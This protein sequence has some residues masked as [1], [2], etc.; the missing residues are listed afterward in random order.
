MTPPRRTLSLWKKLLF[1]ILV[2]ALFFYGLDRAAKK[3]VERFAIPV[4]GRDVLP[5]TVIQNSRHAFVDPDPDRIWKLRSGEKHHRRDIFINSDGFRGDELPAD[6]AARDK[7]VMIGDSCVFG[8]GVG[9][10][11]TIAVLLARRLS[12]NGRSLTVINAGVPGYSSVQAL[13]HLERILKS[14]RPRI[15]TI[16]IGWN[17]SWPT[18]SL[19]DREIVAKGAR[20]ISFN[21]FIRKL[22][23]VRLAS[24][25]ISK[26][27]YEK[28]KDTEASGEARRRVSL[29]EYRENL[30]EMVRLCRELGATPILV[31][32]PQRKPVE[33]PRIAEYLGVM[34]EA[35]AANGVPLVDLVAPL[36]SDLEKN[37]HLFVDKIHFSAE[38]SRLIAGIIARELQRH[39]LLP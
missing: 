2:F 14:H 28:F 7:L 17:D 37:D 24:H 30:D 5:G 1:S 33:K 32:L 26:N 3:I 31:T 36:E 25:L 12:E 35:A 23:V 11:E 20:V 4:E 8:W 9:H 18:P 38:G 6:S 19:S 15:V 16:Q 39:N 34:R 22:W 29:P 13:S 21:F 10:E 27:Y